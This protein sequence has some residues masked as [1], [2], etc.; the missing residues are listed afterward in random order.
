MAGPVRPQ[1]GKGPENRARWREPAGE[2]TV[3]ELGDVETPRVRGCRCSEA[4]ARRGEVSH[5][6]APDGGPRRRAPGGVD[7][8]PERGGGP[9][10]RTEAAGEDRPRVAHGPP[11]TGQPG[12]RGTQGH[13]LPPANQASRQNGVLTVGEVTGRRRSSRHWRRERCPLR[14]PRRVRPQHPV[15]KGPSSRIGWPC[16]ESWRRP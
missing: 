9:R 10:S 6:A 15:I 2:E 16:Q 1:P 3:A 5:E 7:G 8:R 4:A 12:Q 13:S 11:K 14:P